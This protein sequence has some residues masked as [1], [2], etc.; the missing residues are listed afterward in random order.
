M[1]ISVLNVHNAKLCDVSASNP[2]WQNIA[3]LT[4]T[5]GNISFRLEW[6]DQLDSGVFIIIIA[7]AFGFPFFF[8][9]PQNSS[10]CRGRY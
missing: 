7:S 6:R 8:A 3:H 9:M 4:E 10:V 2:N 1:G 5:V